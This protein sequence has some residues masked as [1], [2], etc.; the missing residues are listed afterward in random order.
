MISESILSEI[1]Q[2]C[3]LNK[4]DNIDMFINKLIKQ[5]LIIEKYGAT[6][7]GKI[8]E[9][10]IIKEVPVEVIKEVEVKVPVEVIKEV[11]ITDNNKLNELLNETSELKSQ[12][13]SKELVILSNEKELERLREELKNKKNIYGE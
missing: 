1:K 2:Y 4:I 8:V 11:Y 13:V 7:A 10:E 3:I 6:P 5:G 12:L 9:K